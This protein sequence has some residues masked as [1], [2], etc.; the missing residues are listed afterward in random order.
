MLFFHRKL[1]EGTINTQ[2]K[3]YSKEEDHFSINE[4]TPEK[5]YMFVSFR[6]KEGTEKGHHQKP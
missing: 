6:D 3:N 4:T 1:T 5:I 2:I